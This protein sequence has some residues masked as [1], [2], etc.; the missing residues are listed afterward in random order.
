MVPERVEDVPEGILRQ[1]AAYDAALRQVH[2]DKAVEVAI[3]WTRTARL[4]PVPPE[5]LREALARATI[6]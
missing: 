2:P 4:M 3:L 1:M 5:M 6:S